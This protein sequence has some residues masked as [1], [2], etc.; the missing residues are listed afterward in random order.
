MGDLSEQF[1]FGQDLKCLDAVR[2]CLHQPMKYVGTRR[3]I[4]ISFKHT[5]RDVQEWEAKELSM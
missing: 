5:E 4:G 2:L 3:R 1:Q